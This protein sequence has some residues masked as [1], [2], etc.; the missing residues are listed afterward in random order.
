MTALLIFGLGY[1]AGAIARRIEA[2]GWTVTGTTRDG[3]NGSIPFADEAA[4]LAA[5]RSATHVLSSVPPD[6][7][8]RDPVLANYG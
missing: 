6:A 1:S 2:R 7:S 3:R 4:V 8:G 5:M